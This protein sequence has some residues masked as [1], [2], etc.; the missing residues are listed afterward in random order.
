MMGDTH[1]VKLVSN[2]TMSAGDFQNAVNDALAELTRQSYTIAGIAY[3]L[4]PSGNREALIHYTDTAFDASRRQAQ[5]VEDAKPLRHLKPVP[6][7]ARAG[8][9]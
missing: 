9:F 1:H 6:Q 8:G 3:A 4:G 7:M 5:R 2:Y